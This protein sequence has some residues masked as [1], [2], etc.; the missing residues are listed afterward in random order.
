MTCESD[1]LKEL[2]GLLK[3]KKFEAARALADQHIQRS[4]QDSLGYSMRARI[5]ERTG[6]EC[7]AIADRNRIVALFPASAGSYFSRAR[8]HMRFGQYDAAIP[9]FSKAAELDDGWYGPAINLYRAEC[10]YQLG[11]YDAALADCEHVPDDY[12]FP[13]FR[14]HPDGSKHHIIAD[15]RAA[16]GSD[17]KAH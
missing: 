5:H 2:H 15:I 9:D 6:N 4:P 8:T 1:P 10:H 3:Q 17:S 14:G 7:G 12:A 11:H 13:G 16:R